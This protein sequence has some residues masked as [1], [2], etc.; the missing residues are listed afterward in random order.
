M[1]GS[2]LVVVH[3]DATTL[4]DGVA[5]RLLTRLLDIQSVRS[6]IHVVVTG[7]TL[8]IAS[9]A[10]VA[11]NPLVS[12]ID[13]SAVHFWWGDERYVPAGDP[14]RNE[15]Q[16]R[17]ALLDFL[18]SSHGL[19]PRNVHVAP[20]FRDTVGVEEA[21]LAYGSDLNEFAPVGGS[22]P[23][24][25]VLMLGVG[26]DAHVASLF[27][28]HPGLSRTGIT[29][30]IEDSPKPPP[31]RITLTLDAINT[32]REVWLIASGASKADAV[33]RALG[34]APVDEAPAGH[35]HGTERTL[36]LVDAASLGE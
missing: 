19:P 27:P 16:A 32:A 22:L 15:G 31:L 11:R 21:A 9:L 13:W 36:W 30:G 23:S 10:A 3:P 20:C 6:P 7:G 28:G 5:A 8:G 2:P 4:A 25:D 12:A 24:F 34:S 17:A 18:V 26:P 33:A 29:T 35:V 14:D 1:T